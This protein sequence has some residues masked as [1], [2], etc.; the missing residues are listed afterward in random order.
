MVPASATERPIVLLTDFGP[1]SHYVGIMKAVLWSLAPRVPVID[2]CHTVCPGEF[3]EAGYILQAAYR[4]LPETAVIV[5]VVDPGVGSKRRILRWS[6]GGRD[7]LCPDNG[8]LTSLLAEFRGGRLSGIE[9]PLS[10]STEVSATFHGRDVFAPMAAR[11]ALDGASEIGQ[12]ITDPVLASHA[13]CALERDRVVGQVV[14]VD[15][16]GNL[17]TNISKRDLESIGSPTVILAGSAVLPTLHRTYSDVE[18][19]ALLAYIGSSGHL[20]VGCNGGSASG[21]LKLGLGSHVVARRTG[22]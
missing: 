8:L 11:L 15:R 22:P 14:H 5:A 21:V 3:V 19:S 12:E 16:F 7:V 10:A 4:H 9:G 2:L 17:I 20:E 1:Q 18:A 13:T 6:L